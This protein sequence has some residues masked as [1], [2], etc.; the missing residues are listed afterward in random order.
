MIETLNLVV[1]GAGYVGLTTGVCFA[2]L[3]H[4]VSIVEK[5]KYKL[6]QLRNLKIPF[7]ERHLEEL[8]NLSFNNLYFTDDLGEVIS[9]AD[10]IMIAVGTPCK[11]NGQ[12]DNFQ[13]EEASYQIAMN[14]S[15]KK[16]IVIIIK[17]TVPIGTNRRVHNIIK[18]SLSEKGIESDVKVKVVSNPEFLREGN[19]LHDMFYPDRVIV[20]ADDS[21]SIDKIRQLYQPIL[22]QNFFPPEF[23]PRP[24]GYKL[25]P[26]IITDPV[27]AEMIKYAANAFLATKISFINEIAGLCEK[28]GA[29]VSEV[30]RGIG[31]DPR[32]GSEFLKAGLGWGGSCFPKD[33]A[34]LVAM[35]QE[36][37]YPMRLLEA[38]R[39][40]N[41][42][43]RARTVEK[44]QD[45]LKGVRG[46]VIGILGLAFKPGTDDVR[47]APALHLIRLLLERE[48]HVRTHDPLAMEN[49]K[50]VLGNV[51]V[52]FYTDPY[53]MAEGADALVLATEWPEYRHLDLKRLA[54]SMRTPV[55]LDGRNL[56]DP[57]EARKAG[58]L[59]MGIGR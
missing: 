30:A 10:V 32:I 53:K 36:F 55:L 2:Y 51:N 43:Q 18:K 22:E 47:E 24:V 28:V 44:L 6:N 12:A 19:A 13:V 57:T 34:A 49:A 48:A 38:T 37:S 58:F 8:L 39:E 40:V 27:S 5:D 3:G 16:N 9:K 41:L 35:G 45:A 1:I 54:Q 42:R 15:E 56:F 29:D 20:G 25:P 33:T 21:E 26:F 11:S 14:L 46:R 7:Y 23:L 50:K 59:Y 52:E 4:K 31:L 17:S